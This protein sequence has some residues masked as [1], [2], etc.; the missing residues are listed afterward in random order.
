MHKVIENINKIKLFKMNN[1]SNYD[2]G[3]LAKWLF[4]G[5]NKGIGEWRNA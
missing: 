1:P 4:R 5:H 2:R 3:I